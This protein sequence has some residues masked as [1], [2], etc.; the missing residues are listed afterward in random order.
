[1]R[2]LFKKPALALAA[3][4]VMAPVFAAT[5][6]YADFDKTYCALYWS[7]TAWCSDNNTHSW[8]YNRIRTNTSALL[9]QRLITAAGNVRN[10]GGCQSLYNT[11]WAQQYSG[12]TPMTYAQCKFDNSG[13]RF[14]DCLASTP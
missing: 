8:D 12:G 4:L 6:A 13:T 10:G 9:C 1:M 3:A 2:K 5:P 11:T 7:G 14:I